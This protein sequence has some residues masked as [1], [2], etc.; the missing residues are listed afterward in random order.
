MDQSALTVVAPV[1]RG[2]EA[3]LRGHLAEIQRE[4]RAGHVS[5]ADRAVGAAPM[6]PFGD[7]ER[8]HFARFLVIERPAVR[9][10]H[11]ET[12]L[13]FA[14]NFDGSLERHLSDLAEIAGRGLE[15]VFTYCTPFKSSALSG[16]ERLIAFLREHA[17]RSE[18]FYVG[19]RARS[20]GQIHR[21]AELRTVLE[22]QLGDLSGPFSRDVLAELRRVVAERPDLRWALTPPAPTR[23]PWTQKLAWACRGLL[24]A[25]CAILWNL[26]RIRTL[27]KQDNRELRRAD[28]R[29][30][31]ARRASLR[32]ALDRQKRRLRDL[33]DGHGAQNQLSAVVGVKPGRARLATLRAVLRAIDALG[34][35][36]FDRG[37]LGGIPSIHFARWFLVPDGHGGQL[38]V[39]LTNYDGSWESYL[40]QFIDRAASGLTA[41]WSHCEG[42]PRTCWLRYEGARDEERFKA[43][44]LLNQVETQVWYSAYPDL[45]VQNVLNN[46]EIRRGLSRPRHAL[47]AERWTRRL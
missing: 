14:S 4:V 16:R 3:D 30:T 24:P 42:F 39:F 33:E 5:R 37:A 27:E 23:L 7:L 44:V 34:H 1:S 46:S 38:L 17:V 9:D 21:E 31:P 12:L 13:V 36:C 22:E 26:W 29:L 45:T 10:L 47:A 43:Y 11:P 25:A 2:A 20:V 19:H 18:G 28:E 8:L 40:G 15:A 35:I 6:V 32:A 41:I